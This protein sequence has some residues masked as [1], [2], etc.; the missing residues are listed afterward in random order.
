[1]SGGEGECKVDMLLRFEHRF[2]LLHFLALH[3]E[4]SLVLPAAAD[5]GGEVEKT[6]GHPTDVDERNLNLSPVANTY[7][8]C[9]N[10]LSCA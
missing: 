5:P 6:Q 1:M 7:Q 10:L 9:P 4:H 3:I 8:P 2:H